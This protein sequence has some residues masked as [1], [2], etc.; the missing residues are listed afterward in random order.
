MSATA[1]A[2]G[3]RNEWRSMRLLEAAG[4]RCI[5]AAGSHTE[6]DFVAIGPCDIVLVQVKTGRLASPAEREAMALFPA[7][8]NARRLLHVWYPRQREPRVIEVGRD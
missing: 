6:W 8:A 1:Y 2:K 5:R 3:R 4:Y 7:P